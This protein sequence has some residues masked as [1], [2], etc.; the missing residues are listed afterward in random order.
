MIGKSD[1][2][3]IRLRRGTGLHL[4]NTLVSG[5]ATCLRVQGES[6]NLLGTRI[7][8]QGVG[9]GCATVNEGDEESAVAGVS[10]F[11]DQRRPG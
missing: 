11:G 6:L 2:R 1:E 5:S 4:Y 7:T 3:A 10:R 8:F 9:L